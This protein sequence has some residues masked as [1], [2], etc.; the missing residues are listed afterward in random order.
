[1]ATAEDPFYRYRADEPELRGQKSRVDEDAISARVWRF[2][3]RSAD[4]ASGQT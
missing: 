1:M 4:T 3:R 2:I